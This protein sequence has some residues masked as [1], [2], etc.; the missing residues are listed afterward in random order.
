M[1]ELIQIV[2]IDERKLNRYIKKVVSNELSNLSESCYYPKMHGYKH[3]L[4]KLVDINERELKK[5]TKEYWKGTKYSRFNIHNDPYTI[6]LIF[7][8][9]YAL[10]NDNDDLFYVTMLF[11]VT[12]NYSNLMHSMIPYCNPQYFNYALENLSNLHLFK[13]ERGIANALDFLTKEYSKRYKEEIKNNDLD[14]IGQFI[15]ESRH[16]VAQS[17]RSLLTIYV[18]AY[19]AGVGYHTP[20]EEEREKSVDKAPTEKGTKLVDSVVSKMTTYRTFDEK[21]FNEAIKMSEID[22]RTA[23]LMVKEL[24]K[25]NYGEDIREALIGFLRDIKGIKYICDRDYYKYVQKLITGKVKKSLFKDSVIKL[26]TDV[27]KSL[28]FSSLDRM[29][30]RDKRKIVL[31]ISFYLTVYLRNTVC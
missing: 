22:E 28:K 8:M 12:K 25:T 6:L 13:R 4:F 1:E 24:A 2:D 30:D 17:I 18:K 27:L 29:G 23:K 10:N 15:V 20:G 5:F 14:S 31:F 11:Y 3:E 7:L 19:E 9:Y 16:R 26:I 21:S